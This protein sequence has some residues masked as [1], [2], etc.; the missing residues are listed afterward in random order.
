MTIVALLVAAI[1]GI[2]RLNPI[3]R[4]ANALSFVGSGRVVDSEIQII[5]TSSR[6]WARI[7]CNPSEV[8]RFVE[9]RPFTPDAHYPTRVEDYFNAEFMER[10]PDFEAYSDDYK[11]FQ[12]DVGRFVIV[13]FNDNGAD[14][15]LYFNWSH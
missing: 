12:V 14:E 2:V 5:G 8:R 1:F 4:G 13:V 3:D 11:S 9:M 6:Y 7:A 15:V 10:L